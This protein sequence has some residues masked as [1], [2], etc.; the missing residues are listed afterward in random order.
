M[1]ATAHA[2]QQLAAG[3]DAVSFVN[4]YRCKD[5][6]WRWL[7]WN[8][9]NVPG[10]QL[11]Y[12]SARDI[13]ARMLAEEA[14]RQA[15]VQFTRAFDEAP[16]GMALTGLDGRFITV[17]PA[18][19]ELT[20]YSRDE[21]RA[22]D[23]RVDHP[24]RGRRRRARGQTA[25]VAGEP[26]AITPSGACRT[27]P[28]TRSAGRSASRSSRDRDGEPSA[29]LSLL[30]TSERSASRAELQHLADHDPL[31]GLFNRRRFERELD[32]S[33][34]AARYGTGARCSRSTSTTSSTST[35]RSA[36]RRATS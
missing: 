1:E 26:A 23:L 16:I 21:L 35:T 5:G 32:R 11:I 13:T 19:C 27:L 28:A 10:E 12:A 24:S 9:T 33:W 25:D 7:E 22:T 14:R 8:S 17:N 6:G 29:L 20:G 34:P 30:S 4:R 31:T 36:T 15:E 3:V 2:A 18:L